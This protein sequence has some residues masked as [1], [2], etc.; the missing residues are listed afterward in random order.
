MLWQSHW[1]YPDGTTEIKAQKDI[2]SFEEMLAWTTEVMREFPLP[3]GAQWLTC[4]EKSKHWVGVE[5]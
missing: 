3:E 2:R 5:Q 1:Q 4:N